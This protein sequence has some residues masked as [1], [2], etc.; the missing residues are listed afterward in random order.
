[1]KKEKNERVSEKR[2]KKKK[3]MNEGIR[4]ELM[5]AWTLENSKYGNGR[6]KKIIKII[7]K[8]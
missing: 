8:K 1:M 5:R 6:K 7:N 4:R 2:R 3:R